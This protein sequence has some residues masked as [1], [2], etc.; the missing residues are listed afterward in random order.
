[1][2]AHSDCI[3]MGHGPGV[4]T[5]MTSKQDIIQPKITREANIAGYLEIN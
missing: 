2:V 1:V 4:T 3:I 5:I